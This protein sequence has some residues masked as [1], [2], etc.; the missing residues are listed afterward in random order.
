MVHAHIVRSASEPR[1]GSGRLGLAILPTERAIIMR[2]SGKYPP[3]GP[4]KAGGEWKH[5][6]EMRYETPPEN[7]K[8]PS[9]LCPDAR[10]RHLWIQKVAYIT[11]MW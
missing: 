1:L 9:A 6:H 3:R 4:C 5:V 10:P 7:G 2:A 8:K 11:Q